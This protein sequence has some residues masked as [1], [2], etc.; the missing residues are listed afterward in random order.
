M[1]TSA[2]K[3]RIPPGLLV[4]LV[5]FGLGSAAIWL[6]W[7]EQVQ[8]DADADLR[9]QLLIGGPALLIAALV[10]AL[11]GADDLRRRLPEAR[12]GSAL[13]IRAG[14]WMLLGFEVL[15]LL[16]QHWFEPTSTLGGHGGYLWARR[17]ATLGAVT[18]AGGVLA[19]GWDRA[20][21][22]QLALP[23]LALAV[24]SQP[25]D[26]ILQ[27]TYRVL[28]GEDGPFWFVQ[29]GAEVGFVAVLLIAIREVMHGAAE[30][31]AR[32]WHE[33]GNGYFQAG[34]ALTARVAIAVLGVV[35]ALFAVVTR[36]PGVAKVWQYGV[37]L[38]T[39]VVGIGF[40]TAILRA[41]TDDDHDAPVYRLHL[42]AGLSL[43]GVVVPSIEAILLYKARDAD[44]V[45]RV[46][47]VAAPAAVLGGFLCLI[48]AIGT[49]AERTR[50]TVTR[51]STV[52]T[53]LLV[54]VVSGAAVAVQ[55]WFAHE[56]AG[57]TAK[58]AGVFALTAL[59]TAIAG[60]VAL[61]QVARLCQRIAADLHTARD[62]A[63]LPR[64]EARVAE[65]DPEHEL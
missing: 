7:G 29:A 48:S 21:V 1:S 51:E 23:M 35:F 64:A 42:A 50:L 53:G 46:L 49:V 10:V 16:R 6:G 43:F 59:V 5:G 44:G 60:V 41:A 31:T 38:A 3:E 33:A 45:L 14:L 56:V 18:L 28:D 8:G 55:Q 9:A 19:T 32:P 13:L 15:E 20:R 17:L 52:R 26:A 58:D 36:S 62:G 12:R 39:L 37:P 22:R 4:G 47:E 63:G 27:W 24:L 65:L 61:L 30:P 40:V 25:F 2:P 54:T 57:G 34:Q 11:A